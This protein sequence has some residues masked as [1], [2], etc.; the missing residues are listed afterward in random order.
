MKPN[1]RA[2]TQIALFAVLIIV[3]GKLKV[4]LPLSPVPF[5]LQFTA[6]LLAGL[7]LGARK[8]MLAQSVYILLGL[9]G[10]PVF[11]NG[12]GL[13][14]VLQPSFG[15]LPGMLLSA[16]LAGFLADRLDPARQSLKI[17]QILPVTLLGM[18]ANYA[19]GIPYLYG[20][21]H[22][23][24]GSSMTLAKAFQVGMLP[25]VFTDLLQCGLASLAG[26]ALRRATRTYF[27]QANPPASRKTGQMRP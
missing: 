20:I 7:V 9:I 10:L 23:Y 6:C 8:A 13:F 14:Y 24:S 4:Q 2:M 3:G 12:G 21:A 15:F 16:G 1:I 25:F 17:W 19:L 11:A 26:P 5:T 18:L 27:R 22:F